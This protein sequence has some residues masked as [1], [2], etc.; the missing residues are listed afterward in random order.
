MSYDAMDS[1]SRSGSGQVWD[2]IAYQRKGGVPHVD[3]CG[4]RATFRVVAVQEV[5]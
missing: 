3:V 5:N 2:R 4:Y 1:A